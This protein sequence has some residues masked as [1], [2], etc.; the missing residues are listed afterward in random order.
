M[1]HAP[2]HM[3]T[4]V[5]FWRHPVEMIFDALVIL[6]TGKL[7]GA[8]LEVIYCVLLIESML[9]IFHHSNINT[10]KKMRWLGYIFQLPEQHLLHHQYGLHRWNYGTVTL[11]DTI[12]GTV[13]IPVEWQGRVGVKE[14]NDTWKLLFFRY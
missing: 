12:F 3:N 7:L 2:A 1:H 4:L 9:E 5:T 13:C 6:V 10:P 11:W 8:S 14:W